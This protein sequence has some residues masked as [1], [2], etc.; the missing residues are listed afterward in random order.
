[1]I[2]PS[3]AYDVANMLRYNIRDADL[4]TWVVKELQICNKFLT[5]AGKSRILL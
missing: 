5:L 4:D 2:E 3:G 1:M